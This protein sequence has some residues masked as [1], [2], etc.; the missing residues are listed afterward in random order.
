ML[1]RICKEPVRAE[2]LTRLVI[3]LPARIHNIALL[4]SGKQCG[5]GPTPH[6]QLPDSAL[7]SSVLGGAVMPRSRRHGMPGHSCSGGATA[8]P[9]FDLRRAECSFQDAFELSDL[10]LQMVNLEPLGL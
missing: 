9:V 1:C 6:L 2:N 7:Q 5:V 3:E 10:S 8:G 4:I